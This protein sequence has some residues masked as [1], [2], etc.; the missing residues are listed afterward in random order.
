VLRHSAA[1]HTPDNGKTVVVAAPVSKKVLKLLREREGA[2]NSGDPILD[3][4][5]PHNREVKAEVLSADTVKI[6]KGM[7]V[8]F[9]RWGGDQPL[10]GRAN[11]GARGVH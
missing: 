1:E 5:N 9:E 2:L 8:V 11:R 4:G 6:R 7:P 10:S 3:I